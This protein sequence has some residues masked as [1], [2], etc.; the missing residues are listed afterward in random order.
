[1]SI[2]Q[3]YTGLKFKQV[4]KY[5]LKCFVS[6][7]LLFI[8]IYEIVLSI[9][10]RNSVSIIDYNNLD[11][12]R[13]LDSF[14]FASRHIL[15]LFIGFIPIIA[16]FTLIEKIF[17][18][19]KESKENERL[20]GQLLSLIRRILIR[21]YPII[22]TFMLYFYI[23]SSLEIATAV[24]LE[25]FIY[26]DFI[27]ICIKG[28]FFLT[29]IFLAAGVFLGMVSRWLQERFSPKGKEITNETLVDL[30]VS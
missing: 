16:M 10:G 8:L 26:R 19:S 7:S 27:E 28:C 12:T 18:P 1:M 14:L 25:H 6:V 23:T 4:I 5:H 22:L 21:I 15:K 13:Q 29:L 30:D 9:I 11:M 24:G 2:F 17:A 3:L 20:A